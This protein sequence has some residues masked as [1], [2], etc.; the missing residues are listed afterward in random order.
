M[1]LFIENPNHEEI[2]HFNI[3]MFNREILI[4]VCNRVVS[5]TLIFWPLLQITHDTVLIKLCA[6]IKALILQI[7][8]DFNM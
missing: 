2:R 1:E 6:N 7:V 3:D 5:Y 8:V 4:E